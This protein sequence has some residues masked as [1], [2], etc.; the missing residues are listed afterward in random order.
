MVFHDLVIEIVDSGDLQIEILS[1]HMAAVATKLQQ[2]LHLGIFLHDSF[3][4][5]LNI[6]LGF[7][8]SFKNSK[9]FSLYLKRCSE[10]Y[11][12]IFVVVVD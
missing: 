11:A 6:D 7:V 5:I 8:S 4:D 2:N 10:E 1:D 3:T 9:S 12:G